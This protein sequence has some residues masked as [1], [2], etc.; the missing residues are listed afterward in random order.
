M[1]WT[2]PQDDMG[3]GFRDPETQTIQKGNSSTEYPKALFQE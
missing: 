3:W 1:P 2:A